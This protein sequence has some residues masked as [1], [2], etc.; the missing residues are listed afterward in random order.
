VKN[1]PPIVTSTVEAAASG[2]FSSGSYVGTLENKGTDLA[3]FHDWDSKVPADVKSELEQI[4][5]DIISGKIT[6][7]SPSQPKA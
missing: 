4:K 3:P 1:I 7:T 5:Q 2:S 6:V